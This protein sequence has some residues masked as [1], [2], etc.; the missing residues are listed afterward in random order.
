MPFRHSGKV[1]PARFE[2]ATLTFGGSCSIQLSYGSSEWKKGWDSNPQRSGYRYWFSGPAPRP[3]GP[4]PSIYLLF[5]GDGESRTPRG[6]FTRQVSNL[7]PYQLGNVTKAW[8]SSSPKRGWKESNP[9]CCFW[10][11]S[12]H[13]DSQPRN[14]GGRT[15]TS[16]VP[17]DSAF[18]AHRNCRYATPAAKKN[19]QLSKTTTVSAP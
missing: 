3:A 9:L 14:A 11:A 17:K 19:I 16:G 5:G 8:R 15:R 2:L 12:G 6:Y 10:R 7:L 4:L 1:N 18:T 13:H